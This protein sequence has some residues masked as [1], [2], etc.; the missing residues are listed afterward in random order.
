MVGTPGKARSQWSGR[1][2]LPVFEP[3][4]REEEDGT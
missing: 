4:E 3:P 2:P 1:W